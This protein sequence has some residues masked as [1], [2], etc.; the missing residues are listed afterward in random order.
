MTIENFPTSDHL[1]PKELIASVLA[2]RQP[3]DLILLGYA[4]DG[5][6]FANFSSMSKAQ[7]LWLLERAKK[8]IMD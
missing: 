7:A 2:H 4:N 8:H 5:E 6:F 1:P 3:N